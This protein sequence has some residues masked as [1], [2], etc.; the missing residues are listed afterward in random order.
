MIVLTVTTQSVGSDSSSADSITLPSTGRISN[1]TRMGNESARVSV[2]LSA[3]SGLPAKFQPQNRAAVAKT[4]V[5]ITRIV[6]IEVKPIPHG[7]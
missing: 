1:Q 7:A 4:S 3:L 2:L 5:K 6:T